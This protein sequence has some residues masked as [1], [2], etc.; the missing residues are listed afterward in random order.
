M[1]NVYTFVSTKAKEAF[2][3]TVLQIAFRTECLILGTPQFKFHN[4]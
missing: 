4:L 2:L 3:I 1:Y